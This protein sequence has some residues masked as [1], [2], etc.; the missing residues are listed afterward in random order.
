MLAC[1]QET[2]NERDRRVR[3]ELMTGATRSEVNAQL[4]ALYTQVGPQPWLETARLL[5]AERLTPREV[6]A[7][8]DTSPLEIEETVRDL[9]RR[10]VLT[11][12]RE[13]RAP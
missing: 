11:L 8:V 9:V 5:C 1:A 6:L 10:G 4:Y 12:S 3:E 2:L 7:R 13:S